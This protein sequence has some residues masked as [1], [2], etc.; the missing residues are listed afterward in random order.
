MQVL[1]E[2]HKLLSR[3]LLLALPFFDF[4]LRRHVSEVHEEAVIQVLQSQ[5][6]LFPS[7]K[8]VV[9]LAEDV[10]FEVPLNGSGLLAVEF[11]L[12]GLIMDVHF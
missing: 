3:T 10:T 12:A 2:P 4:L 1:N 11:R 9:V 8:V 5:Q 7:V 6:L